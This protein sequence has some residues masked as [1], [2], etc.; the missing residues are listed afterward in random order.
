VK[1]R[2][3][4]VG[5]ALAGSGSAL[6]ANSNNRGELDGASQRWR[7][8]GEVLHKRP[9]DVW[10]QLVSAPNVVRAG[11]RL[12]MYFDGWQR[13]GPANNYRRRIGVA[14]S[15]VSRGLAWTRI[16]NDPVLDLGPAGSIDC[17]WASYPWV[18]P[19]T[20]THWHMYYAGWGGKFH[21]DMPQRK[22]W[23]TTMAES[24]DGGRTWRRSGRPL[25]QL[26]RPGACDEH[27]TGSCAVLPVGDEYWMWYTA[28]SNNTGC[29]IP[30]S[31]I[32]ARTGTGS[33]WPWQNRA[34]EATP[35]SRT[36]P[37]P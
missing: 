31:R 29:G 17:E 1:R 34:T 12:R 26:G 8:L 9:G 25:L 5:A 28:I 21:P 22:I 32:P 20:E 4:L 35:F 11:S 13:H 10:D 33:Q 36:G 37:V 7:K 3:F 16:Q 15:D 2:D 14:E 23:C 27:G 19:V 24:D 18:V 6:L 30:R